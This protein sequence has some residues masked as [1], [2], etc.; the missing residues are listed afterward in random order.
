MK[1]L[2]SGLAYFWVLFTAAV[3]LYVSAE[4]LRDPS[5]WTFG[6]GLVYTEGRAGLW[7][8]L[9]ASIVA[10]AGCILMWRRNA[11][12]GWLLVAYGLFW[13][14]ALV[15]DVVREAYGIC[16]LGHKLLWLDILVIQ[17]VL[18]ALFLLVALWAWRNRNPAP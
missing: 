5:Q 6:M 8:T 1:R 16:F 10:L 18:G 17:G 4:I 3:W 9:P 7:V 15:G 13:G 12:G 14:V 2:L 11:V